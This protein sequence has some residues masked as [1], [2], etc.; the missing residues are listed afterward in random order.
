MVGAGTVGFERLVAVGAD[1]VL[2]DPSEE[3]FDGGFGA[4][5]VADEELE[6]AE[7]GKVEASV[8]AK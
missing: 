7:L 6:G 4:C 8:V 1:L 2:V 5:I 3:F